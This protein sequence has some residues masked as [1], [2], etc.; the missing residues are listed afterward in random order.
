MAVRPLVL[1]VIR[2]SGKAVFLENSDAVNDGLNQVIVQIQFFKN[3]Y[4]VS[5]QAEQLLAALV[6]AQTTELITKNLLH[7]NKPVELTE[8]EIMGPLSAI[9]DLNTAG[10]FELIKRAKELLQLSQYKK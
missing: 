3:E 1:N 8:Q 4:L 5:D 2:I 10:R 9:F 6:L 7:Q